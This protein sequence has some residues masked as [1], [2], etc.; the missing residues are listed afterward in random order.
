MA[1]HVAA[2]IDAVHALLMVA[3]VVGLPLLFVHRWE[4]LRRGYAL[5]ALT[6]IVLSKGSHWLLGS[7]FLTRLSTL[8]WRSGAIDT[9]DTPETWFTVRF[10]EAVFHMRPSEDAIV[11]AWNVL[12]ALSCIGLLVSLRRTHSAQAA[13]RRAARSPGATGFHDAG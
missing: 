2:I 10:A 7:C 4:R 3:W 12:V 1:A 8:L 11:V 13:A 9:G 6:F 5:Y